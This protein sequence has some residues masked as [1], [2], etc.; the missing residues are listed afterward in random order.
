MTYK[1][2]L[3]AVNRL[4]GSALLGWTF[5]LG[6]SVLGLKDDKRIPVDVSSATVVPSA[7]TLD[8]TGALSLDPGVSSIGFAKELHGPGPQPE[9]AVGESVE[10]VYDT[11][12]LFQGLVA[13][14]QT[15]IEREDLNTWN[16]R[17]T[18]QLRSSV[19]WMM[20][21][22]PGA[23]TLPA[24]KPLVRLGHFFTV[25]SSQLTTAQRTYVDSL[26]APAVNGTDNADRT[27]L[28]WAR[29]FTTQTLLPLRVKVTSPPTWQQLEVLPDPIVWN[30][31][32]PTPDVSSADGSW[33][34]QI[35][36][37]ANES[38]G[39]DLRPTGVQVVANDD[40][41]LDGFSNLTITPAKLGL[42]FTLGVS[43]LGSSGAVGIGLGGASVMDIYGDIMTVVRLTHSF[44]HKKYITALEL[45]LP[46]EIDA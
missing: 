31:V 6:T 12:I 21:S 15:N 23:Q 28:D 18:Y 8:G 30:G 25:D 29:D 37:T 24:E 3:F 5:V 34:N 45:A 32:Q 39:G 26:I 4:A 35:A 7:Y 11:I 33:I 41:F 16:H 19:A 27:Y 46:V 1:A 43:R 44:S 36:L 20:G 10:I 40:T 14:V 38:T 9:L 17:S 42:D 13:A 2:E 22:Q